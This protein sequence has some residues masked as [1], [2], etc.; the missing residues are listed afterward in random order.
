MVPFLN[1]NMEKERLSTGKSKLDKFSH[2][3]S[4]STQAGGAVLAARWGLL[5]CSALYQ[6][7]S[8]PRRRT[9]RLESLGWDER[10]QL[11]LL[12]MRRSG[13]RRGL[14][15]PCGCPGSPASLPS[16]FVSAAPAGREQETG[17]GREAR[18]EE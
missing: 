8:S 11:S 6:P 1:S 15:V 5:K 7:V 14:R 18:Q 3:T 10:V 9:A 4:A 17:G 13:T 12:E 16:A 2:I